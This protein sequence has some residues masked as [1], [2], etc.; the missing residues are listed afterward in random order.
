MDV[1]QNPRN[2]RPTL[3]TEGERERERERRKEEKRKR[4]RDLDSQLLDLFYS[5][6]AP[7]DIS[8]FFL[9]FNG[10]IIER[11]CSLSVE[12]NPLL[13]GADDSL[14]PIGGGVKLLRHAHKYVSYLAPLIALHVP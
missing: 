12:K 4:E 8:G 1:T 14:R 5:H 7:R 2:A 3:D 13:R 11:R 10:K 9:S 6:N